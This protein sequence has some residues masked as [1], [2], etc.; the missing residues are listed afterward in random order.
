MSSYSTHQEVICACF[1]R[2]RRR[3]QRARS[4]REV[5]D[6]VG[7][8]RTC[9][10]EE[11]G[12]CWRK[13]TTRA[14]KQ[15][16]HCQ[17]G[18]NSEWA[19]AKGECPGQQKGLLKWC[20]EPKE[21]QVLRGDRTK[22][23]TWPPLCF[24]FPAKENNFQTIYLVEQALLCGNWRFI[25][26]NWSLVPVER[27]PSSFKGALTPGPGEGHATAWKTSI[28]NITGLWRHQIMETTG[29]GL[30]EIDKCHSDCKG[31]ENKR[32]GGKI[33]D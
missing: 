23:T 8:Q 13:L 6:K 27:A 18:R 11:R 21:D 24:N 2:R 28:C 32:R 4:A 22:R 31:R 3:K 33:C 17:E 25:L 30:M 20:L 12:G 10:K 14:G 19:G 29:R 15:E 9:T 5:S 7:C 16:N 1:Q 26:G